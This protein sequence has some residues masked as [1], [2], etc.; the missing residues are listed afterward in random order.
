MAVRHH[1][2]QLPLITPDLK[3]FAPT[4]LPSL[5]GV[6][7]IAFDVETCDPD[8]NELGP[9]TKRNGYVVGIC[10]GAD[11]GGRWYLPTRHQGGGNLDEDLVWR[12]ARAEL[13]A[14]DGIVVGANLIYDLDYAANY[15]VTFAKVKRFHDVQLAEP[16]LD[17]HR[18]SYSLESLCRDYLGESKDETLLKE[19]AVA[20]GFGATE[21]MIKQNL[22]RLPAGYVGPYG[23]GDVDRPL[24]IIDLQLKK[25]EEQGLTELF[26][27][28]SRLLPVLLGMR[29]RGVRVDVDGAQRV[30]D[31]LVVARDEAL[32]RIR[33]LAGPKAEL[34]APASFADAL[35]QRGLPVGRTAKSGQYS[36]T[37]AWM[38]QHAGDELVDAIQ[39][40]RKVNT[41]I[42]TFI[43]GHIFNHAIGGRIYCQFKQLKDDEG[44]TGARFSS[45][46]PNLQNIP[47]RDEELA[48][49]VR[50]LFLPDEGESWERHDESQMEYRLQVHYA[51]GVGAKE[52]RQ[53]YHDDPETDFHKFCAELLHADPEDKVLRK[54]I[55]NTNFAKSYGA[56]P[57]KLA[58]TF[59]C[60]LQEAIDF[61]KL[62]E[63]KLPF[64]VTTFNAAQE[65]AQR[66]GFV[67][68]VLGRYARFPL[69]EPADNPR[70]KMEQRSRALPREAAE[71]AYGLRLV[72]AGT[73]KALNNVLQFSNADH[74]KKTMVDIWEAGICAPDVLG[75]FLLQVHDELDYSVP[76]TAQADEAVREAKHLMEN[77]IPL[78][79]PVL[80][81]ASRGKDWGEC[82]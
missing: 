63:E 24:R 71:A 74:V 78:R 48:P 38:K 2:N 79:V 70:R 39:A 5:R 28:E 55:K 34:M 59:N 68:S 1:P 73:Y 8:L 57:P 40:G 80:V 31:R 27:L 66:Q 22:W 77:A 50:G 14:Y 19:A 58:Q 21:K 45:A 52:A 4:E 62:Y 35:L 61:V 37:S 81:E 29:R 54:K 30:R 64:T 51:R 53:K 46:N 23:E 20:Y 56:Q 7:R 17:E 3:W 12:W 49:L 47:A 44:G 76:P 36:I 6:K 16:L 43:D 26:D 69:W 11:N 41:I 82:A 18:F 65:A 9:G 13:N 15:G 42:T 32:A 75:A 60:S 10:I 33:R 72:R 67:R 25:L